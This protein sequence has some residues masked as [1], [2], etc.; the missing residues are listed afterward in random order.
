VKS[1]AHYKEQWINAL[2]EVSTLKKREEANAK[3]QLKK[4]QIEL[5]HLRMRYLASEEN[6]LIKSDEKQIESIRSELQK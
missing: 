3:A 4:Q 1:K 5:D 6:N 2:Q